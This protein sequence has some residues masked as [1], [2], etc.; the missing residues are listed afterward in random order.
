MDPRSP[1]WRPDPSGQRLAMIWMARRAALL[2]AVLFAP[3]G[4]V[5]MAMLPAID[6]LE[7]PIASALAGLAG[8]AG[9]ALLGA[10]LAPAAVGSRIDGL[11]V[12]LALGI[13]VPVAAVTSALIGTFMA[14]SMLHGFDEGARLAGQV[15]RGGVG[16][17]VRLAPLIALVSMVWVVVVRRWGIG[18]AS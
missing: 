18:S 6:P 3:V 2:A 17:A 8:M 11:V 10:G 4:A 13:G 9:V 1:S 16:G 7:T 5:G 15:L 12:G 14:G